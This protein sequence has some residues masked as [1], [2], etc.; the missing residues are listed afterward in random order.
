[1]NLEKMPGWIILQ[2]Q[3]NRHNSSTDLGD[4]AFHDFLIPNFQNQNLECL[5]QRVLCLPCFLRLWKN[6]RVSGGVIQFK[7]TNQ[8]TKINRVIQKTVLLEK[9]VSRGLPV[10]TA[11]TAEKEHFSRCKGLCK[12][13]EKRCKG[14][15]IFQH[16]KV[17][18]TSSCGPC[19]KLNC[20]SLVWPQHTS[21]ALAPLLMAL[22]HI[23]VALAPISIY[24][25]CG[26]CT[27]PLHLFS[28]PLHQENYPFQP[29]K[30]QYLLNQLNCFSIKPSFLVKTTFSQVQSV[31]KYCFSYFSSNSYIFKYVF[32]QIAQNVELPFY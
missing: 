13:H 19:T 20:L 21:E 28:W 9:R 30:R 29:S 14:L 32:L 16:F 1:M 27:W 7:W 2:V 31:C 24:R 23:Q 6:N 26:P 10:Y 22:A 25:I 3:I 17:P 8:S 11:Q 15:R 4:T 12:G 18:C 5:L